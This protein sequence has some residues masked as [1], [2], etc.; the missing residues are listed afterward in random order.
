MKN[1]I[2]KHYNESLKVISSLKT[3]LSKIEKI[4]KLLIKKIKSK[5]NIFVYGNGGSFADSSHF[6]GELTATY[7]KKDRKPLPFFLLSSNMAALT[8]WSNDFNFDDYLKREFSI[9]AKQSDILILFSTSGGNLKNKQSI[10]LIKLAKYAKNKNIFI[11]SFL[12]KG[13]GFLKKISDLSI[14]IKSQNTG[15]IQEA[16]KVIMHSICYYLDD[17]F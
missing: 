10:N 7:L 14:D 8:A 12:G 13:G 2:S 1:S 17:F 4:T 3:E 16:H 5:N 15:A 6:V 11:I 9:F